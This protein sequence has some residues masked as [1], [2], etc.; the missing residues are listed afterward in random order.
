MS[1]RR[2]ELVCTTDAVGAG[3]ATSPQPING[4]I[5]ELRHD[6]TAW[7]GT[8]DYT[9]LRAAS[10]GGGTVANL[11]NQVGSFSI[12]PAGSAN[13]FGDSAP[14]PIPVEGN[15]RMVIAQ[16]TPSTAGTVHVLYR[17]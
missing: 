1:V 2:A 10:A 3:T 9:F 7:G 15:L 8:I 14:V 4:E 13:G 5:L 16:A 6:G 11:T 17:G 12:Y